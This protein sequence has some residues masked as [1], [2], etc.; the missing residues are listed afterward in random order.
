MLTAL[1][2]FSLAAVFAGLAL[3]VHRRFLAQVIGQLALDLAAIG[4]LVVTGGGVASGWVILFLLPLAGASLLLPSV[5]VFFTCALAVLTILIDAGVRAVAAQFVGITAVP[6]WR[7]WRG[8]LRRDGA[9][10]RPERP[11]GRSRSGSRALAG[12]ICRTSW[13]SIGW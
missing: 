1:L 11:P 7:V 8:S 9:A 3:Y 2:Y 12:A 13:R 6:G 10:A 5:L 4:V